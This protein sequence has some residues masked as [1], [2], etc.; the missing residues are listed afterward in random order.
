[1]KNTFLILACCLPLLMPAQQILDLRVS[2]VQP[3]AG[4][5]VIL[6]AD[7]SFSSGSCN[8]KSLYFTQN[9]ND[10][11]GTALH[12]VGPLTFICNDTDTFYA[13]VLAPGNYRFIYHVDAGAGQPPCTPGIVPGP[14]DTLFFSVSPVVSTVEN[15]QSEVSFI[16]NEKTLTV[17][18]S[19]NTQARV[20]I[21]NAS[22]QLVMESGNLKHSIDLKILTSGVYNVIYISDEQRIPYRFMLK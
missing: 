3:L 18:G 15:N 11:F 5:T 8:Q 21:Y 19:I 9:G 13:G 4:D 1:M 12:C 22:G 14:D 16:I 2:P 20:Y 7:V 17:K 6:Y 10:L